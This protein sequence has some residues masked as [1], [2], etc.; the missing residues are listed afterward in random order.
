LIDAVSSD[1]DGTADRTARDRSDRRTTAERFARQ[2][3]SHLLGLV[4]V[5]VGVSL[6]WVFLSDPPFLPTTG[7][8]P[9]LFYSG[10]VAPSCHVRFTEAERLWLARTAANPGDEICLGRDLG[11]VL[12]LL[13]A[14]L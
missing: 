5:A 3:G 8:V 12:D 11:T 6:V 14:R 1:P 13:R 10:R 4:F 2:N 7:R 9:Q